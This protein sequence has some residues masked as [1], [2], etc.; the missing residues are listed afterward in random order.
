MKGGFLLTALQWTAAALI[1]LGLEIASSGFWFMWLA[2][3][4]FLLAVLAYF[5]LVTSFAIQ[6]LIF[7]A[8]SLILIIFTRPLLLKVIHIKDTHSNTDALIGA[9]GIVLLPISPMQS[10]QVKINGE[11]WTADSDKTLEKGQAVRVIS[12]KGVKLYVEPAVS[13]PPNS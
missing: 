7:S 6:F 12:V 8:A 1:C 9:K 10:G 5:N 3:A 13:S 2:I 11:I 4:A